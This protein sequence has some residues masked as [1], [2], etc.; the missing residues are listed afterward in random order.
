MQR[1]EGGE[2]GI[3]MVGEGGSKK[4]GDRNRMRGRR[5]EEEK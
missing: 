4:K 1:G 3:G 5:G 2:R